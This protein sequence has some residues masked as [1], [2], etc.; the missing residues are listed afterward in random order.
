MKKPII[1]VFLL[2]ILSAGLWAEMDMGS[3]PVGKWMDSNY[4]ASWN[5]TSG[6]ITITLNDGTMAYDFSDKTIENFSVNTTAE[7]LVLSFSCK[8]NGRS[9]RFIKGLT[10][11]DLR[12]EMVKRNGK[13][14]TVE[15]PF[16]K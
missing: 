8:E 12:L 10:S 9:Y 13:N 6:N 11:L 2:L 1:V 14:Y 4:N 15:M 3:F 16:Q 7:G 5:F